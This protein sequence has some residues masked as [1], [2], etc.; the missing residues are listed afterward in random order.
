MAEAYFYPPPGPFIG[1]RQPYE[2]S[3]KPPLSG[4][5]AQNPPFGRRFPIE[6]TGSWDTSGNYNVL[7]RTVTYLSG[8]T[9]DK[10]PIKG[11][12]VPIQVLNAWLPPEW[13]IYPIL[14]RL[15]K[16]FVGLGVSPASL[17]AGTSGNVVTLTGIGTSW[18]AGTPGTPVFTIT[19]TGSGASKTAQ[20][21]VSSTSATLTI[22][23]GTVG[24]ITV[25]DPSTGATVNIN[26][27]GSAGGGN[28]SHTISVMYNM[29]GG[30]GEHPIR[31][32]RF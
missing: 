21:V 25:T 24:T 18:S 27:T 30:T 8:P 28:T 20:T 15:Y 16:G 17:V 22:T 7:V 13:V 14:P 6:I 1:G 32:G 11:M 19:S 2:P 10:P 4:P 12:Q 23:A 29:V 3:R 9:A 26:V 31:L 5:A